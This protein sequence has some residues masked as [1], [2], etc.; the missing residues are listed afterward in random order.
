MENFL[1]VTTKHQIWKCFLLSTIMVRAKAKDLFV[2]SKGK[3]V[4]H[5]YFE[6]IASSQWPKQFKYYYYIK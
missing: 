3:T 4:F 6:F 2:M 5:F 1:I